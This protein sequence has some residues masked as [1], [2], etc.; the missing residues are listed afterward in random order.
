MISMGAVCELSSSADPII[1]RFHRPSWR[2]N[3]GAAGRRGFWRSGFACTSC[4]GDNHLRLVYLPMVPLPRLGYFELC[5]ATG[6]GIFQLPMEGDWYDLT[7]GM[8]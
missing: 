7:I 4:R 3:P 2:T 8:C 5:N 6:T 1:P